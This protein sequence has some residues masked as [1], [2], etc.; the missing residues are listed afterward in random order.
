LLQAR[1]FI[2]KRLR[3]NLARSLFAERGRSLATSY[4][5]KHRVSKG[6]S[7][8]QSIRDRL[9]YGKDP[10]K[11]RDGELIAAYMCDPET[12]AAE[13]VLAKA[14]YKAITGREQKRDGNVLLYQIRQS[15]PQG[16]VDA[17]TALEIGY[18][19]ALRWT[20]GKHAFFVVSH[21]D[22]PHPHIHIYYNSTSLD[23]TR[24]FRDFWGSARA[25]QRLSDR[26]CLEN[27]LSIITDPKPKSKGKYKHY[28]EWLGD[29]KPPSFQECLKAQIDTCLAQKP[30]S[31][32]A[33][34]QAMTAAGYEVKHGR[35]GAI[36]FRIEGQDNFTRLRSST[37]GTGYGSEDIQ[38]VIEG[39]IPVPK[40]EQ[41]H[42]P[43]INLIVD[44]QSK[45]RAG[46]GPAYEQWAKITT[47]N[48]WRR[49]S[50]I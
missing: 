5:K 49:L 18:N 13:F 17:E 38:A 4:L 35:G 20:K 33:F 19:F 40:A 47:S 30:E 28:G 7:I 29:Q 42:S 14:E 11:T 36:S 6:L 3:A 48:K 2:L 21:I 15:F 31:F 44:I 12:A 25:V 43:K 32:D 16:E 22:R 41:R 23:C 46:K 34:L 8:L 26:I 37:L 24:K 10:N 1:K 9:D 27:G 39:R 45:M 50:N